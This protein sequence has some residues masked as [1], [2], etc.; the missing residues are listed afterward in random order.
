MKKNIKASKS[1]EMSF[2][3]YTKGVF[4]CLKQWRWRLEAEEFEAGD[5]NEVAQE[6]GYYGF[7]SVDY[8]D[9]VEYG[10]DDFIETVQK[11][12]KKGISADKCG[13]MINDEID[14][15]EY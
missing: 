11:C 15:Q 3:E 14:F 1:T 6:C 5:P 4:K 9:T 10:T 2:E 7:I 12:M 8:G 13:D